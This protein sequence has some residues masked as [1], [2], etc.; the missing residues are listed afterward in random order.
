M[1]IAERCVIID[2][3][4]PVSAKNVSGKAIYVEK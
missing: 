1:I 2:L 3:K 4:G